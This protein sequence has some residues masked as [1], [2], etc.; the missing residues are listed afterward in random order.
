MPTLA[1]VLLCGLNNRKTEGG[2]ENLEPLVFSRQKN[3]GPEGFLNDSG[4]KNDIEKQAKEEAPKSECPHS[5]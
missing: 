4:L 5:I 1:S 3:W 2:K